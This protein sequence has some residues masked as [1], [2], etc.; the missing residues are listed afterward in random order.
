MKIITFLWTVRYN[1]PLNSNSYAIYVY[2]SIFWIVERPSGC[3]WDYDNASRTIE[4]YNYYSFP[5]IINPFESWITAHRKIF[6]CSLLILKTIFW[7][8]FIVY[9]TLGTKGLLLR[10]GVASQYCWHRQLRGTFSL[11]SIIIISVAYEVNKIDALYIGGKH[12]PFLFPQ[13]Y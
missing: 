5:W 8:S 2:I 12:V 11:L 6:W 10:Y 3:M 13:L 9:S 4:H 1:S 7:S